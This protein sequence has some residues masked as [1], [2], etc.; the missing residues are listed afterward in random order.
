MVPEEENDGLLDAERHAARH[1]LRPRAQLFPVVE[2]FVS[3]NGE[4]LAAGRLAAFIRFA[5]CNLWCTYCDT[6]CAAESR[7]G[8]HRAGSHRA[9]YGRA[10]PRPG[11]SAAAAAQGHLAPRDAWCVGTGHCLT[12]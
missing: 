2:K 1:T 8:R 3:V 5:G 9:I 7:V 11:A 10:R 6:R 4:G 12:E